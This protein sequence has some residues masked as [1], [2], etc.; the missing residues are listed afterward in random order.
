MEQLKYVIE[1]STIAE[2]LGVQNF[3]NDESAVLELVKNAYDA[4]AQSVNLEFTENTLI[5]TDTG[6]GM[7][8][9]DIKQYWMHVGKSPKDYEVI[10]ENGHKRIL[11]GAKGIG[12]FALARLGRKVEIHTKKASQ[13]GVI[14]ETD[15]NSSTI[16]EDSTITTQGTKIII[17]G[18]RERWTKTKVANLKTFL[19][20]TYNATEMSI[21]ISHPDVTFTVERYFSDPVLGKDYLSKIS[22][23]YDCKKQVLTTEVVS[24]E[25]LEEA[26]KYCPDIDITKFDTTS[27]MVDE[28]KTSS[29]WELAEEDLQSH[30]RELGDFFGEFYFSIKPTKI[31]VEKFLYNHLIDF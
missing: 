16:R 11:A 17:S 19:S 31:D 23:Y 13:P 22:I 21:A 20:K 10:D 30:L 9:A 7:S 1:D 28:L 5:I 15:W 25:F 24:D 14:W 18:L 12:R 26:Q 4:K 27:Y 6:D 3:T 2:L 8:A 29:E